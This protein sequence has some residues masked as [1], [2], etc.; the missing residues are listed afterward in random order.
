MTELELYKYLFDE[1]DG[2]KP[3]MR[4]HDDELLIFLY[5]FQVEDFIKEVVQPSGALEDEG[6][7]GHLKDKYMVMDLVPVCEAYEI[8]PQSILPGDKTNDL[9]A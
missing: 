3:E 8:D 7:I 9:S 5:Y 6:L 2:L 4:W 1:N